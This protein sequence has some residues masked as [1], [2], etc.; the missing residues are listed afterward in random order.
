M[1]AT[2]AQRQRMGGYLTCWGCV[3]FERVWAA[4]APEACGLWGEPL[5]VGRTTL[6]AFYNTTRDSVGVVW[7]HVDL[8]RDLDKEY[9][10]TSG[11]G[12]HMA[13]RSLL[14]RRCIRHP[15]SVQGRRYGARVADSPPDPAQG[16]RLYPTC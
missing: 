5:V 1:R 8:A 14:P 9:H 10:T 4:C 15:S 2:R 7:C 11:T 12:K 16:R 3:S 6:V 13:R